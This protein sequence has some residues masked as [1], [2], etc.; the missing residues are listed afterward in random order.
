MAI[1]YQDHTALT[2]PSCEGHFSADLWLILD[3]HEQPAAVEA[4]REGRF[5]L[6][7]CQH[8]GYVSPA[9]APLLFH[10]NAARRVIFAAPPQVAEYV[11]REQALELHTIMVGSIP[12]EER[13]AYLADVQIAQDIAGI[14]HIL[15]KEQRRAT[16]PPPG[17][18]PITPPAPGESTLL[19]PPVRPVQAPEQTTP[20]RAPAP[21]AEVTEALL[22][23][24]IEALL[25]ADTADDL[26]PLL[27]QYP[28]LRSIQASETLE[29]LADVAVE[30]REYELAEGL[31][32]V[33]MLLYRMCNVEDTG[34][35]DSTARSEAAARSASAPVLQQAPPAES[36]VWTLPPD[37]YQAL[38]QVKSD[39]ALYE[40][41]EQHPMLLE[42]SVDTLLLQAIED[43]LE[44]GNESLAALLEQRRGALA[45]IR[46]E[47]A[48]PAA[49]TLQDVLE[50]LLL[51]DDDETQA[52]LILDNPSLLS[53]EALETLWQL[54]SEAR[55]HGDEDL[56]VHA[57]QC[58]AVLRTIRES[59]Q[60]DER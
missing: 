17:G 42:P 8:C 15:N 35:S 55:S 1:S 25:S 48:E 2:C 52:R 59:W 4:L 38:L 26:R 45:D 44:E 16:H 22:H 3:A 39:T 14:T 53:D 6:V 34:D 27:Q 29:Q 5:N 51:A 21:E 11:W 28:V 7:T 20:A 9:G 18:I 31:H 13:Q 56:A 57:V 10:D 33:R 43:V 30:Q 19:E 58:R 47:V 36:T 23:E 41:L 54:S 46:R 24:A 37:I 40:L 60:T 12:I 49:D 32:R 50:A